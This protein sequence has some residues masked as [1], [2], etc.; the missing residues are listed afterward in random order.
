MDFG[1]LI[2]ETEAHL[3]GGGELVLQRPT[4]CLVASHN[5]GRAYD[6]LAYESEEEAEKREEENELFVQPAVG[7]GTL[8]WRMEELSGEKGNLRDWRAV[9]G[10]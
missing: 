9:E 2:E 5:R 3:K 6:I 4:D 10:G 8:L 1:K 7:I